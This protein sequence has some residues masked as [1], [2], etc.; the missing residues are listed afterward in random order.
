M[1]KNHQKQ[2]K[3][4][5]RS[6][7]YIIKSPS[8]D[9]YYIGSTTTSLKLRFDKHKS[10]HKVYN[11]KRLENPD[12]LIGGGCTSFN[13]LNFED[14][15]IEKLELCKCNTREELYKRESEVINEFRSKSDKIVNKVIPLRHQTSTLH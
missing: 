3:K 9:L 2:L 1:P 4:Y 5:L 14:A 7:I 10:A 6:K 15:Y 12:I 13:I 8:T 11:K